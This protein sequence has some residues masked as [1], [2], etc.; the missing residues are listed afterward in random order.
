MIFNR[1]EFLEIKTPAT[2]RERYAPPSERARLKT[3]RKLDKH[4]RRFIELSP[5]LCMGSSSSEGA[6][7]SPRGGRP[8][9]VRVLDESTIAIP[10]WPGNNRLDSFT[11]ILSSPHVAVLFLIPGVEET[12]RVNGEARLSL[13]AELLAQ[14]DE[15]GRRPKTALVLSVKEAYLHCGKALIRARLWKDDFKIDRKELPPYGHMLKDQIEISDTADQIQ[16]SIS[17]AYR[18]NLY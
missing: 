4:C 16:A 9:F 8:G 17:K 6:D 13:D 15:D 7:V 2:L 3:L 18:D 11:N 1:E 5:F 12:L 10:D 14:W